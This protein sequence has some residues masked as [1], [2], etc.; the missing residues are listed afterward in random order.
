MAA[1]GVIRSTGDVDLLAVSAE[2]LVSE[3]WNGLRVAGIQADVRRGDPDD[4]LAGVVRLSVADE[5]P[6]D[7]VVGKDAWQARILDRAHEAEIGGVRLPV[8]SRVDVILLKLFA[9]GPQDLWDVE[10][11][12]AAADRAVVAADVERAL[13]E[14]PG[15]CREAWAR[16]RGNR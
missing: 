10:A 3:F 6:L 9:G 13:S 8:S 7:L 14:L 5:R 2:C 4:P 15:S 11:L 12:L 1:H 16:V